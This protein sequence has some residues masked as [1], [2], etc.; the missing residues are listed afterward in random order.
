[1]C[2]CYYTVQLVD[3]YTF[4]YGYIGS[5]ATGNGAGCYLVA[6]PDWKGQRPE[7]IKNV[8]RA[9]TQ[10][11][12]ATYRTQLFGPA[13]IEN[14]RKVQ[15]GYKVQTLSQFLKQQPPQR[16]RR[17]SSRRSTRSSPRPTRSPT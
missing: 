5:R 16:R 1:M 15:A 6:G 2:R 12:L 11:S 17:S 14:V 13:D 7:S 3:M 10:C 9:E 8:F 4:N